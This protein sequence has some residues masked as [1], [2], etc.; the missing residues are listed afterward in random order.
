VSGIIIY[1]LVAGV[2]VIAI[3]YAMVG[4][5]QRYCN[6]PP[7]KFG[8]ALNSAAYA[9]Y[10]IHPLVMVAATFFWQQILTVVGVHVDLANAST[11][12]VPA[13]MSP[14]LRWVGFLF[15]LTVTQVLVWLLALG[16]KRIP[17]LDKII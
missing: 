2:A 6:K 5:C 4:L 11:Y 7:S 13:D 9:A 17:G 1:V 10:I 8:A 15:V 3:S 16:L 12:E 14:A